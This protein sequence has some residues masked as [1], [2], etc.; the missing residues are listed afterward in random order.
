MA[1]S[2]TL[3]RRGEPSSKAGD[4]ITTKCRPI[5]R[6]DTTASPRCGATSMLVLDVGSPS[7]LAKSTEM[8]ERPLFEKK[9][10]L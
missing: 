8:Q 2:S 6:L 10:G 1:R 4:R 3:S 9:Q 5:R 7:H